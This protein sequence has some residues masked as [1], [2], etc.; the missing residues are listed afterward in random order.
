MLG[1]IASI[2]ARF[3]MSKVGTALQGVPRRAWE[4]LAVL[5][6]IA[7]LIALH[8][9]YAHAAVKAAYAQGAAD[10]AKRIEAQAIT[11]KLKADAINAKVATLERISNAAANDRIVRTADALSVRGPGAARCVGVGHPGLASPTSRPQAPAGTGSPAAAAV[12][13]GDRFAN[14]AAVPWD[15]L[16]TTGGS[17]DLNRAEAASW[18][19]W[20]EKIAKTWP[21]GSDTAAAD[22]K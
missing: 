10:A 1:F 12:P 9:H 7:A 11:V 17:C 19:S 16:V 18:R 2:A 13:T 5:G 3:T 14:L 4:A 20:Y 21:G 8:Q 6:Y 15:W 22:R